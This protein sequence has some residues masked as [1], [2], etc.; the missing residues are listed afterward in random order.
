MKKLCA[1]LLAALLLIVIVSCSSTDQRS[2][3]DN[4]E[5]VGFGLSEN[6]EE[7]RTTAPSTLKKTINRT[8]ESKT[9]QEKVNEGSSQAVR[10]AES[11]LAFT[12]F[13]R[14]GLIEQLEYE[15]F[16]KEEATYGADNCGADWNVQAVQSA[17]NYLDFTSFSREGLIEQLEYEGFTS[18]QAIYGVDNCGTGW[19]ADD[20][21][22]LALQSAKDYLSFTA[23]SREGL[24]EQL[25]YEGFTNVQAVY[26]VDN[27][28]ANWNEQATQSAKDYLDFTSFSRQGLIDQLKFEGFTHEQAVYGVDNCGVA[29]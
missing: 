21:N 4:E 29:W 23:F 5:D 13:S 3:L 16:T 12:S 6:V 18:E 14:K 24:I 9:T 20:G 7:E 2:D 8:T 17:N 1:V 11:Y 19:D 10:S 28:G 26:A 22:S 15:G 25:E 27:C